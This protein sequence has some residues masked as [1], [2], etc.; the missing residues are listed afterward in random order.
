VLEKKLSSDGE[1]LMMKVSKS[2]GV[3]EKNQPSLLYP[4]L[5]SPIGTGKII[6]IWKEG[7]YLYF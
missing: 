1:N 7:E 6:H 3:W 4:N 5:N 2:S